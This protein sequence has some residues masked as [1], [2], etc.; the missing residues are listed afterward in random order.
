MEAETR[1]GNVSQ[2][3]LKMLPMEVGSLVPRPIPAFLSLVVW[4][5]WQ[6][7]LYVR[8]PLNV[9]GPRRLKVT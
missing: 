1:N 7:P 8:L 4:L 3:D 2:C 5:R 9:G 6:I